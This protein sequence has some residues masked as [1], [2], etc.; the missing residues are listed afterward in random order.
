MLKMMKEF[1]SINCKKGTLCNSIKRIDET[2]KIDQQNGSGWPR[3][4]R[5]AQTIHIFD[6][7]IHSKED[8][9]STSQDP[10]KIERQTDISRSSVHRI[11]KFNVI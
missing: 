2:G 10:R 8:Q 4:A 11:V 3:S 9:P 7:F 1:A 5:R 6:N